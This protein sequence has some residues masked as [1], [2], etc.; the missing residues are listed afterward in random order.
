VGIFSDEFCRSLFRFVGTII[1]LTRFHKGILFDE[2]ELNIS[3]DEFIVG[4]VIIGTTVVI[5]ARVFV[6]VN[7]GGESEEYFCRYFTSF[8][9]LSIF[10]IGGSGKGTLG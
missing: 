10:T 1:F 7:D 5:A 2:D 6:D 8:S 4:R 9:S 3:S